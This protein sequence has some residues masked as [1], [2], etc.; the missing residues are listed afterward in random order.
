MMNLQAV[1]E[2]LSEDEGYLPD[3]EFDF[4]DEKKA[5]VAYALIQEQA[6][7]L[8]STGAYYW[9]TSKQVEVP[10]AFGQNP[11]EMTLIGEAETFCV[12]FGGIRS[13]SGNLIPDLGVFVFDSTGIS[14]FYR[15]GKEWNLLAVEGLLELMSKLKQLAPDTTV[16]HI[17]NPFDPD[18]K[19]LLSAFN[20]YTL[21]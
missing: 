15:M 20:T 5:A 12:A 2:I 21:G 14:L 7:H 17:G 1:V 11:A 16:T 19:I 18:G 9:S 13:S 3:I 8:V 10:I 4:A 6:T